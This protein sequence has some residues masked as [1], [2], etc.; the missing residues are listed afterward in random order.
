M[1]HSIVKSL[2]GLA[3]AGSTSLAVA[4]S[5]GWTAS[6]IE[7]VYTNGSWVL[8]VNFSVVSTVAVD[9]LGYFDADQNGFSADHLVNLY[10]SAGTLLASATVTSASTLQ[11]L[12][13]VA[14]IAPLTLGPGD[15]RVVGASLSDA[16]LFGADIANLVVDP[17]L[18]K[19]G[20][21]YS[22]GTSGDFLTAPTY[23]SRPLTPRTVRTI[24]LSAPVPVGS[25][26]PVTADLPVG[27]PAEA[28]SDEQR[29][30]VGE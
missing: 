30:A 2:A 7:E 27:A 14:S 13:R 12:F 17:R 29:R 23:V 24:D 18:S 8:G 15:Y 21:A 6:T 28:A 10:D 19:L 11:G 20:N 3:L 22:A 26:V 4:G 25:G 16:Y 5:L 9:G 1:K